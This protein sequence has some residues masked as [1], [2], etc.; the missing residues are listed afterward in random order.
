MH[1]KK[2]I[3]DADGR[4]DE[5]IK[6]LKAVMQKMKG[7]PAELTKLLAR[8]WALAVAKPRQRDRPAATQWHVYFVPP[9]V[10]LQPS[11]ASSP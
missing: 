7:P 6:R 8:G 5:G 2:C 9:Y 11:N 10:P 1:L 4:G 3:L